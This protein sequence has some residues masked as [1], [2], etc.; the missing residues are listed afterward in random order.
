MQAILDCAPLNP[1]SFALCALQSAGM[2]LSLAH[3]P[4]SEAVFKPPLK[5]LAL[6]NTGTHQQWHS[7]DWQKF[8]HS[9]PL[10]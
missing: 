5:K 1:Q 10:A 4:S 3:I 9:K 6:T 7:E 2:F 8:S